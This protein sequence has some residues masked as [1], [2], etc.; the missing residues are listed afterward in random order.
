[1]TDLDAIRARDAALIY[2]EDYG[3]AH[4]DRRALLAEVDRLRAEKMALAATNGEV[5]LAL[6]EALVEV[7][8]VA[9]TIPAACRA[10]VRNERARIRAAV[11]ALPGVFAATRYIKE[12]QPNWLDR[13]AVLALLEG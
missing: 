5:G 1:M 7:Q 3:Q 4:A 12:G 8:E 11:E 10:A 2:P 13:A 6:T 9:D